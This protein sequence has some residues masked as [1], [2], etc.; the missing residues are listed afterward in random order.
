MS[1]V[2]ESFKN[3]KKTLKSSNNAISEMLDEIDEERDFG[4]RLIALMF[5][6]RKKDQYSY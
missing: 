2:F 1:I 6:H 3:T 5:N 4:K